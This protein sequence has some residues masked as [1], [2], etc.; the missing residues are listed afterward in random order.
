MAVSLEHH[1]IPE[2]L[3]RLLDNDLDDE[4]RELLVEWSRTD[5]DA[6]SVYQAFLQDYTIIKTQVASQVEQGYGSSQDSLFDEA[7][8]DALEKQE[9]KAPAI[10]IPRE[11]PQE[12]IVQH[13]ASPPAQRINKLSL[14]TAIVSSAALF[15]LIFLV[16]VS[17]DQR[18]V[19]AAR[20]SDG[21]DAA[22]ANPMI[23]LSEGDKIYSNELFSLASGIIE[24][25]T[26][27][28][29]SLTI[30]GP[31]AF[32]MLPNAD[33]ELKYG[34]VYA[35]VSPKGIGFTVNTS[36]SKVID[37]GTE[38]GIQAD[39]D[40]QMELHVFKGKTTLIYGGSWLDKNSQTIL[41]KQA[42]SLSRDGSRINDIPIQNEVFAREID[43]RARMVWRGQEVLSLADMVGDGNGLGTGIL[44]SYLDPKN[45]QWRL[46]P[47]VRMEGGVE[48]EPFYRPV[49]DNTFV[50]GIF[51]PN[52]K[53]GPIE[54]STAGDLFEEV[55]ETTGRHW[56]GVLNWRE[57]VWG[58]TIE[59]DGMVYGTPERPALLMHSNI[60]ITFDLDAIRRGYPDLSLREF[61]SVYGISQA[62]GMK[63]YDPVADMWVLVDGEVR[64][65]RENLTVGDTDLVRIPL[66]E[67][68]RF[69]TLVATEGSNNSALGDKGPI[70][71]DWCTW[72]NPAIRI[73]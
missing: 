72:G 73:E 66:Y 68:D 37:L 63:E 69:L 26:V 20:F 59:L 45:S 6:V 5:P 11:M 17:P 50:D 14:Y 48:L 4:Q 15:F 39:I 54:V 56:Y 60:G 16:H 1:D 46:V 53:D 44:G 31:A 35:Q 13:P 43:S 7:V 22:W 55:P 8:W 57:G 42:R 34:R 47:S 49:P 32:E 30:E 21:I 29:V 41:Q 10:E 3:I 67:T 64:F 12:E 38:F 33:M 27:R 51:V 52:G 70:F 36:N 24:V 71:N 25:E 2:L 9:Q 58:R 65:S 40:G 18:A 28:G 61:I 19:E 23:S 62:Y